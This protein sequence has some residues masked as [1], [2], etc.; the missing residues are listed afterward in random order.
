MMYISLTLRRTSS[1]SISSMSTLISQPTSVHLH[2]RMLMTRPTCCD[3]SNFTTPRLINRQEQLKNVPAMKTHFSTCRNRTCI[4]SSDTFPVYGA[5]NGEYAQIVVDQRTSSSSSF[6]FGFGPS[7]S[8]VRRYSSGSSRHYSNIPLFSHL[9]EFTERSFTSTNPEDPDLSQLPE[10][11]VFVGGKGGVGKTT[12]AATLATQFSTLPGR[13]LVVSTDPAH[14]LSDV[15]STTLTNQPTCIRKQ[16]DC[17][18]WGM[19]IDSKESL[20]L[21][22]ESLNIE[23][24]QKLIK[25][26]DATLAHGAINF[27]YKQG[28]NVS[29]ITE[30]LSLSPP[31]ID[32]SVALLQLIRSCTNGQ[33]TRVVVD[34]APTGHTLRLLAFPKFL[35]QTVIGLFSMNDRIISG[36]SKINMLVST[37]VGKDIKKMVENSEQ[38]LET[39]KKGMNLL[40]KVL[41]DPTKTQFIVVT[42]PTHL[43]MEETKRLMQ[44]LRDEKYALNRVVI[45]QVQSDCD[46]VIESLEKLKQKTDDEAIYLAL[47][48]A[49]RSKKLHL[50]ARLQIDG[51]KSFMK[52]EKF[53]IPV[54]EVNMLEDPPVGL[55]ALSKL[56]L[57]FE[58][59]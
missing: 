15:F 48:M 43:A 8:N 33:Y 58:G 16:G 39:L 2:V 26:E 6:L 37:K 7:T 13:T 11:F 47:R 52:E 23:R 25:T 32:E 56:G 53:D 54:I 40:Q 18:L 28:A 31:G 10:T 29:S 57:R 59:H 1:S 12:T 21:L 42:I 55:E 45:N 41:A 22:N 24:I 35:L 38:Q 14:S 5:H 36:L 9:K 17:E 34:T 50:E 51:L 44:S 19:E 4:L 49:N 30:L 3:Q 27:L 20:E 46:N